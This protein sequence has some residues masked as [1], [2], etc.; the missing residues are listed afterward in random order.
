MVQENQKWDKILE[1]IFEYNKKFTIREISKITKIPSSTV[2]RYLKKLRK[3]GFITK[4]NIA[5]ITPYFKFRKAF[6]IIDKMFKSGLIEYLK[7]ELVPNTIIVFGS[8]RKGEYEK[9]SD[10]DLF[11]ESSVRKKVDLKKYEKKLGHKIQ[12][13]IKSDINQLQTNL[14]NN[15]VN[16]I[17]LYG[18]FKIKNG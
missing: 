16:G 3:G 17:K 4:E 15:I 5:I 2:Q 8:I 10:I 6:F 9:D 11:V 13:F 12:L 1:L 14:F 7:K 18:S